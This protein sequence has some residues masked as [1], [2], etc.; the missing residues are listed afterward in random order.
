MAYV[1]VLSELITGEVA[2]C[3]VLI[4]LSSTHDLG[5]RNQLKCLSHRTMNSQGEPQITCKLNGESFQLCLEV[6]KDRS[7]R[8][9]AL[10]KWPGVKPKKSSAYS[11]FSMA[12]TK[13][14]QDPVT[15]RDALDAVASDR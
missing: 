1:P 7:D 10:R 2:S 5:H 6:Y 12:I 8:T 15:G 13:A 11:E 9:N 3:G 4:V 14:S